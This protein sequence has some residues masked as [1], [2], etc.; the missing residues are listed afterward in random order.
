MKEKELENK[1]RLLYILQTV[2]NKLDEIEDLKG[3]LPAAVRELEEVIATTSETIAANEA[4]IDQAYKD[5]TKNETDIITLTEKI[6][7][8]KNQQFQVRNNK[9]YDMLTRELDNAEKK[10]SSMETH[11]DELVVIVQKKKSINEDHQAQLEKL[12]E[13]LT[14]RK[15]ELAEVSKE[16]DKEESALKHERDKI[17]RKIAK[18]DLATYMRI[19]KAKQGRAVVAVKRGACAGCFNSVP[20]QRVLEL[21]K[22]SRI[23]TCEGCGRIL[24]SDEI[25]EASNN[26]L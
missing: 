20:P 6:E 14:E 8:Y 1:L 5:R 17:V 15:A 2:D 25:V 23:Y 24:V 9:E 16:T 19:R 11:I 13:T 21:R 22:N 7:R 26:P 18:P 4:A 10:I 3:D 12:N